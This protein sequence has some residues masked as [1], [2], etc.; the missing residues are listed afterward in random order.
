M[1][2][3]NSEV[4]L[5]V[6]AHVQKCGGTYSSWYVGI[7]TDARSRLFN[8]HAVRENG[9]CWIYQECKESNTA[10]EIEDY[11]LNQGMDGGSGGGDYASKSV[12]AYK[13]SA[14]TR[15]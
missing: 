14:N 9:D 5:S 2:T 4:I 6:A 7:A 10:R 11:F 1:A 13:K 12:Y 8:D 15:E 3:T